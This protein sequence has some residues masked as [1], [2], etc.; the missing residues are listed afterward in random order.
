VKLT[1]DSSELY[2]AMPAE[3]PKSTI[4]E[5]PK[6][7][8]KVPVFKSKTIIIEDVT[9]VR[10]PATMTEFSAHPNL[11]IRGSLEYQACTN[12]VCYPPEKV[13]VEWMLNVK[14]EDL[15][16]VRVAEELQ[17]K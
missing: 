17:R 6:L 16:S 10:S 13:P 4:M 5:F 11:V 15:D 12:A 8:E 3:Y 2:S 1:L 7:H 9:A 14:A